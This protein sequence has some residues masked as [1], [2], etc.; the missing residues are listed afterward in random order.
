MSKTKEFK[1]SAQDIGSQFFIDMVLPVIRSASQKMPSSELAQ[2]YAGLFAGMAGACAADFGK[3][4][5]IAFIR[6]L[7]EQLEVVITEIDEGM[8]Q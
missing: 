3:Q 5:A 6:K 4:T 8:M 7:S 2:L 1:G